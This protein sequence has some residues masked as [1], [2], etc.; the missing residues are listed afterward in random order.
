MDRE[1][2]IIPFEPLAAEATQ[3]LAEQ[4]SEEA[5]NDTPAEDTP[6]QETYEEIPAPL[7]Q[8]AIKQYAGA[9]FVAFIS[10]V[11]TVYLKG[12]APLFILLGSAYMAYLGYTVKRDYRRG[13]IVEQ[14]AVCTGVKPSSIRD[15]VMVTFRTKVDGKER[16]YKFYVPS[17]MSQ[18]EFIV[19]APYVIYYRKNA[20]EALIAYVLV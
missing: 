5:Q 14:G 16:F 13:E 6:A 8:Y 19:D 12:P 17:R 11:F 18:D 4:L 7:Q 15:R 3:P 20:P 2:N 9:V 10:T 1:D